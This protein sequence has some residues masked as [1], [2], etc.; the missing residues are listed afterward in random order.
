M[1]TEHA[2]KRT[3]TLIYSHTKQVVL[4]RESAQSR[5]EKTANST[6]A[7]ASAGMFLCVFMRFLNVVCDRSQ[8]VVCPCPQIPRFARCVQTSAPTPPARPLALCFATRAYSRMLPAKET[9]PLLCCRAPWRTF[10]KSMNRDRLIDRLCS[11]VLSLN[12]CLVFG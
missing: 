4:A 11:C 7:R 10:A 1:V 8:C 3:R 2:L 6:T 9:A 5:R 12:E